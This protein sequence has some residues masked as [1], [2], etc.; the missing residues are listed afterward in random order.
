MLPTVK[1]AQVNA[2]FYAYP[3]PLNRAFSFQKSLNG[4]LLEFIIEC[5]AGDCDGSISGLFFQHTVKES[6]TSSFI[7]GCY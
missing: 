4:T 3:S 1:T 5:E 2:A 6:T 7:A